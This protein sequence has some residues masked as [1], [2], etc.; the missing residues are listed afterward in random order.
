MDQDP[1]GDGVTT[2]GEDK[3]QNG[4]YDADSET[5]PA[6]A[7]T[8]GDGFS[9]GMD[10]FPL[11]VA[12][13]ACGGTI[14]VTDADFDNDGICDQAITV[15]AEDDPEGIGCTP[16]AQGAGDNCPAVSNPDQKDLNGNGVGDDC[17][18]NPDIDG[19]GDSLPDNLEDGVVFCTSSES[20]DSDGDGLTDSDEVNGM[21]FQG[22]LGPCDPDVDDDLIC[23]GPTSVAEK[24]ADGN[25][26][27]DEDGNDVMICTTNANGEADNCPVLYNPEQEDSE[28]DK[29][30]DLCQGDMDGDGVPDVDPDDSEKSD[31]CAFVANKDQND[32]DEDGIGDACDPDFDQSSIAGGC[33][34]RVDGKTTGKATDTI[35][36][37]AMALPMLMF[38]IL[39]RSKKM[40][41]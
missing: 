4:A 40:L 13:Q 21:T 10:C 35:P 15:E 27:K 14:I 31:N 19:D 34:C 20:N 28:G 29:I 26:V 6:N 38:R 8:D 25:T 7:D 41:S 37:L 12:K 23:D 5:D 9:D 30:G 39:R 24:D 18:V 32:S 17:E 22:G 36:F 11:D 2:K 33:G 16:N 1:D 3:N